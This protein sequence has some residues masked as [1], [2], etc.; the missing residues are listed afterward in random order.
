MDVVVSN[1]SYKYDLKKRFVRLIIH[2]ENGYFWMINSSGKLNFPGYIVN[3]G[4]DIL[5]RAVDCFYKLFRTYSKMEFYGTFS[6]YNLLCKKNEFGK[7]ITKNSLSLNHCYI[8]EIASSEVLTNKE[9]GYSLV[10]KT[11]DELRRKV[12]NSKDSSYKDEMMTI[13]KLLP[14]ELTKSNKRDKVLVRR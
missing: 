5:D 2:D 11:Y 12:L 10:G 6:Y 9:S 7:R 1:G 8:V 14:N 3:D 4:D 13:L